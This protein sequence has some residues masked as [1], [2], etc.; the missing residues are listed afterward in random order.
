PDWTAGVLMGR[1]DEGVYYVLDVR[2]DRLSPQGVQALVKRTAQADG[3]GVPVRM[4]Q[5]PGSAGAT[6]ISHYLR[7]LSGWDFGGERSTGDKV[8]RARPLAAQA[9]GGNVRLLRGPWNKDFL[10]EAEVFPFGGHDDQV[11]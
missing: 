9:E 3:Y 6:V 10:D 7:Q 8:T 4:E 1:S 2:R 5:K 11:D